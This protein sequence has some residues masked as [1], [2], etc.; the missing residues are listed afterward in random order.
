MNVKKVPFVVYANIEYFLKTVVDS[1]M[2]TF[3]H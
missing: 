2:N 1:Y 3:T